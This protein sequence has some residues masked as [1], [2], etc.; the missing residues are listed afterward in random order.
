MQ[1]SWANA[2]PNSKIPAP[3]QTHTL[4]LFIISLSE[5]PVTEP[6]GARTGAPPHEVPQPKL[7][8]VF[9]VLNR[10]LASMG[11]I[12]TQQSSLFG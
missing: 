8:K 12:H 11:S 9:S 3:P 2:Q 6:K 4:N 1:N 7:R 10:S 5:C